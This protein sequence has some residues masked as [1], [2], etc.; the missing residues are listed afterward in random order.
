M[1]VPTPDTTIVADTTALLTSRYAKQKNVLG[2]VTALASRAQTIESVLWQLIDALPLANHPMAGGPWGI[3]DM[4]GAIV[5]VPRNGRT[6]ADYTPAIKLQIRINRATGLAEDIIQI[7]ALLVTGATYV[8]WPPAA[9]EVIVLG[10]FASNIQALL[11]A[12]PLARAGGVSGR[13]RFTLL[14]A[15]VWVLTSNVGPAIP[16]PGLGDSRAGDEV[17]NPATLSSLQS[18]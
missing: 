17:L 1:P 2:L 15:P 4:I 9:F 11:A 18:L 13:L 14:G 16:S 8:E 6:D 7:T 5:G 10:D 3:L 12:L